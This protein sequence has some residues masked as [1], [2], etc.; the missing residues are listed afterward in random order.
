[1]GGGGSAMK[2]SLIVLDNMMIEIVDNNK[3]SK[4]GFKFLK[5]K[6]GK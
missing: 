6:L 4:E 2:V 1:M 3:I 5:S